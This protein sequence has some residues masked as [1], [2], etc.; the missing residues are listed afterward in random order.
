M[1]ISEAANACSNLMVRMHALTV[2]LRFCTP[3][4]LALHS[5][6]EVFPQECLHYLTECANQ[7]K[8]KRH[9]ATTREFEA[10]LHVS[11]LIAIIPFIFDQDK[12]SEQPLKEIAKAL[13]VA[14]RCTTPQHACNSLRQLYVNPEQ[15][16][17]WAAQ[18][19]NEA[20]ILFA[21]F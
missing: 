7:A 21:S 19:R 15:R 17:A 2:F 14:P 10:S 3:A 8:R 4:V 1:R 18:A 11:T 13:P 9:S 16:S 12:S 6:A 20:R 5:G